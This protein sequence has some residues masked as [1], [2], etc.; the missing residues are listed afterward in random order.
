MVIVLKDWTMVYLFGMPD[1]SQPGTRWG[2]VVIGTVVMDGSQQR[3]PGSYLCS[4]PIIRS[5]GNLAQSRTGQ[6]FSLFGEGN[7]VEL[8][9]SILDKLRA[10]V[11][12][13]DIIN[14]ELSD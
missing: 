11:P 2:R 1:G 14:S 3:Q 13:N 5:P 10:G 6:S 8:P 9:V 4:D 7:E 12:L